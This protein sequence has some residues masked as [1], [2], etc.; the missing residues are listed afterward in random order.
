MQHP[1]QRICVCHPVGGDGSGV[2]LAA[3][4]PKI[5]SVNLQNGSIVSSWPEEKSSSAHETRETSTLEGPPGKK[6]KIAQ[7]T[8]TKPNV[9]QLI[10]SHDQEHVIAVTGEDKCIRVFAIDPTGQLTQLSER[11]MPK[12]PCAI[13][14]TPDNQTVILGDKHG[15]VHTLP[16]FPGDK[17]PSQLVL[18]KAEDA[19]R[20]AFVPAATNLTVHTG[21]NRK[22]LE[23]QQNQKDLHA[24]TKEPPK[25][26]STLLLG[27][28]SMLTDLLLATVVP[29]EPDAKPRHYILTSDR[30]EHI[31]VS[32]GL[33]QTH[34]IE[35]YCL[36]HTEF[37]SKLCILNDR[38]LVSGGGNNWLGVWD[39]VRGELDMKL[40]LKDLL[41]AA[42]QDGL[43]PQTSDTSFRDASDTIA[44][45]GLWACH[46]EDPHESQLLIALEGVPAL[47]HIPIAQLVAQY[48]GHLDLDYTALPGNLL[49]I[50]IHTPVSTTSAEHL[51]SLNEAS[52]IVSVDNIHAPGSTSQPRSQ[53]TSQRL[54][55]LSLSNDPE[56]KRWGIDERST[57]LLEAANSAEGPERGAKVVAALCYGVETLRKR[58]GG[59]EEEEE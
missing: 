54:L 51:S 42:S 39:W 16:L 55:R 29:D 37:V 9:I 44:V 36:G 11:C 41:V 1:Y 50:A 40:D 49:D 43:I 35:G 3:S 5:L 20:K 33:P 6:R 7:S 22:A 8:E 4:G 15:D 53:P 26:E 24:K 28:V 10:T 52:L 30:D 2:L 46:V 58:G 31:R 17:D 32:R 34:V 27:H 19:P 18:G 48:Q 56:I 47:F 38:L 45:S 25:F 14:V 57:A 23:A 13:A 59:K 12:R 21:R